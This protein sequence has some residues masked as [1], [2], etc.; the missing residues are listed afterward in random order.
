MGAAGVDGLVLLGQANVGYATGAVAMTCD[1]GR[2]SHQRTVAVVVPDD[3]HP[4][5]FTAFPEGVPAE[6]PTDHVHPQLHVERDEGAAALRRFLQDVPGQLAVDEYPMPVYGHLRARAPLD[7]GSAV[8][9][10]AKIVKTPDELACIRRAQAINEQ[11]MAD[12]RPAAQPGVRQTELTGL[13]LRRIFELGATSNTVDP[14]WQAMPPS[15]AAGPRSVTGA[16]V[17]PTVTTNRRLERGDVVWV[18]TGMNYLGYASDFGR[19]WVVGREPTRVQRSQFERWRAV[20]QAVLGALRPGATAR[21]LTRAATDANDGATP[22][23]PHL[24]LCHGTGT[25]SAEMPFAGTDLGDDFDAGIV[26]APGMVVVL[27][28]VIWEDGHAGYRSEDIF[29]I[30]DTGYLALSDHSYEPYG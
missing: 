30:T 15:V 16:V 27:E 3:D 6:V 4:H 2:A 14:I 7:A 24:Y 23:L 13:F 17:F 26:L 18:D 8:L 9:A 29:A 21:D 11:A 28:P 22:W 5:L 20:V 1:A 10:P 12:V 25:D 19:T